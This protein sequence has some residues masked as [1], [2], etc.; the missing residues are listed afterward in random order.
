MFPFRTNKGF[1][2]LEVLVT[3]T[4]LSIGLLG[5]AG[6]TTGV[7]RGNFY[8]KNVTTATVIAQTQIEDIQRTGYTNANTK[9]GTVEVT[10]G[11]ARFSRN[12]VITNGS[13]AANM[14]TVSVTVTWN[15]GTGGSRSV[16]LQTLLAQ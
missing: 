4:I 10:M 1:T 13:P 8:A 14:K 12:T 2:L 6:L 3:L 5:V 9:A 11:G 15:E 16:N 7:L